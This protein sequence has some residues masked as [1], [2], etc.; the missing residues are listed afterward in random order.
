MKDIDFQRASNVEYVRK[1]VVKYDYGALFEKILDAFLHRRAE[2]PLLLLDIRDIANFIGY[3]NLSIRDFDYEWA[4]VLP[5][6]RQDASTY[7][8]YKPLIDWIKGKAN[9]GDAIAIYIMGIFSYIGFAVPMDKEEGQ[10]LL[11][12]VMYENADALFQIALLN[13]DWKVLQMLAL[14]NHGY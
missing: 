5:Q 10:N 11:E 2:F 4:D 14:K 12:K 1:F 13:K 6:L 9:D 8:L 7:K 3:C